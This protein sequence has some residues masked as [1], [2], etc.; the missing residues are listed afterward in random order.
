VSHT[1]NDKFGQ[2]AVSLGFCTSA[3]VTRCLQIQEDTTESLS[4]GHSLLREG[5]ISEEQYSQVLGLLRS[6]L[7]RSSRG[8]AENPPSAIPGRIGNAE[9]PTTDDR[10]EEL[11]GKLAVRAGWLTAA[12]LKACQ[13]VDAPGALRRTL[14]EILVSRGHLT[15]SR[16]Q[17]LLARVSRREM[18]CPACEKTFTVLSIA[19]TREVACPGGC[20]R[21]EEAKRPDRPPSKD[22]LATQTLNAITRSLKRP[23]RPGAR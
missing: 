15:A 10:K 3:Q 2:I 22:P 23:R 1:D 11:L 9:A 21:L 6:N 8:P 5:F 16:A 14:A 4:L 12:E 7:R 17:D 18:H 20:G 13:R 19:N